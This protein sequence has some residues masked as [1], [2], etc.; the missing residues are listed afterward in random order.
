[1]FQRP[2]FRKSAPAPW[3]QWFIKRNHIS[4]QIAHHRPSAFGCGIMRRKDR[5]VSVSMYILERWYFFFSSKL[6]AP[7]ALAGG[8]GMSI[9]S[10]PWKKVSGSLW[11][12]SEHAI[13]ICLCS[14]DGRNREGFVGFARFSLAVFVLATS[15]EISEFRAR[16]RRVTLDVTRD[17]IVSTVWRVRTKL[18]HG[19]S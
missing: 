7:V 13:E 1:M 14:W 5:S 17:V 6:T 9:S 2:G 8:F 3:S 18:Q 11:L 4:Y 10:D 16:F 15:L 19:E 12:V